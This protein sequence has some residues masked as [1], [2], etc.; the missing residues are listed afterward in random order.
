MK[1]EGLDGELHLELDYKLCLQI[2]RYDDMYDMILRLTGHQYVMNV[3]HLFSPVK[4]GEQSG[5][6]Q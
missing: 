2:L 4:D 3:F 1:I 5:K 6:P